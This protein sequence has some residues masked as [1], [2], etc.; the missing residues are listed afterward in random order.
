[1]VNIATFMHLALYYACKYD[2]TSSLPPWASAVVCICMSTHCCHGDNT[3]AGVPS[4]YSSPL[5]SRRCSGNQWRAESLK[6]S[7]KQKEFFTASSLQRGRHYTEQERQRREVEQDPCVHG[8]VTTCLAM[9]TLSVIY[10][11]TISLGHSAARQAEWS[12]Q[13]W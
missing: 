5:P 4:Q 3:H 12:L 6:T 2:H 8:S 7:L 10:T 1:M 11:C 9:I 13:A